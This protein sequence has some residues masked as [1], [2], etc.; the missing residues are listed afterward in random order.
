MDSE[1]VFSQLRAF[2]IKHKLINSK[3]TKYDELHRLTLK[4]IERSYNKRYTYMSLVN[5][6]LELWF[7]SLSIGLDEA[8]QS[9]SHFF[10]LDLAVEG[11]LRDAGYPLD[12]EW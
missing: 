10:D 2:S 9:W 12:D 6:L 4:R 1:Y 11:Y 8:G 7:P 5:E 3:V